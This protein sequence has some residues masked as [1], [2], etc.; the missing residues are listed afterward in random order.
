MKTTWDD[1][2]ILIVGAGTMGTS[3]VQ[4]YAQNGF[5][6]GVL[7]VS[8]DALAGGL[9]TIERELESSRGRIFSPREVEAIRSR[10]IGGR[11]YEEAC[12]G[13]SLRLVI[14]AA[15]EHIDIKKEIFRCLDALTAPDVVLATNSSSLDTNILA[16]VTNRPEKVVWMHYF[17]LP[18]K[19]R[20]AEYAGTDTASDQ[21]KSIARKYLKLGGKIPTYIRRSRKGGAADIIFAALLL[22]A[23]R[24]LEDGS[25]VPTIEAAGQKAY[26]V[27]LGFLELMDVTG[28]PIGLYSMRSF[29]DPSRPDDP[30]YQVYGNFYEPRQNYVDLVTQYERT[31]DKSV[32]RW[33]QDADRHAPIFHPESVDELSDRFLAIGFLTASECVEAGLIT[34]EDLELLTQ[35]AFLWRK[36]PFTLMG[37]Q[38]KKRVRE[39][40]KKRAEIASVQG[41]DFPICNLLKKAMG[42]GS[43]W[44]FYLSPVTMEKELEGAVRRI[45]LSNPRVSNAMDH[46]VFEELK[47]QFTEANEDGECKVIIFDTAP[48][49]SFIAGADVR[50]FIQRIKSKEFEAVRGESAEWQHIMFHIMTGTEKPKVAIVDGQA[51]GGGVEVACAFAL[52]PNSIVLITNRTSFALPE[53]RLGIY[54]GLRGTLTLPQL[55][56]RHT[57]DAEAAVAL[58]RYY[59]LAGGTVT[60]SPQIVFHLGCADA[61]VPQQRRD[62][63]AEIVARAIIENNGMIVTTDQLNALEFERLDTH[64]SFADNRELRVAKDLFSQPD[65]LPTLYAQGRSHLPLFYSTEMK[66]IA[67]RTARRV[68]DSSPNAVCVANYLISR[69]FEEFLRGTDNDALAGFELEHHLCQVFEHPDALIGLEAMVHGRFPEFRRRY[70]F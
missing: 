29:S 28:L 48:I 33:V 41:Q 12:R 40:V 16:R 35:N 55:I 69:G 1:I 36:G 21:S 68:A 10:I 60:S 31:V 58:S 50:G 4:N 15:T 44:T 49:K 23:T 5:C 65:L 47:R 66:S 22:E 19:N 62:D 24:M 6:V 43:A 67:G 63:A 26:N 9:R 38:G 27:P 18:H 30:L 61:V 53:T 3:L 14:E 17:Y 46:R 64:L 20:A 45:T 54:P 37:E 32:V 8:E 11:N 42:D 13:Q 25:D 59:I 39:V 57:G 51:F 56:Y 52:D 70:P 34:V 7:D 2:E